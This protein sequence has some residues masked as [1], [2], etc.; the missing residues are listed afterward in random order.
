[1]LE[2]QDL[3][4]A[5][6]FYQV[7]TFG[8]SLLFFAVSFKARRSDVLFREG[9]QYVSQSTIPGM[10]ND[11]LAAA[12]G[13]AF[14]SVFMF[15]TIYRSKEYVRERLKIERDHGFKRSTVT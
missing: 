15:H 8:A 12:I 9:Y 7:V 5:R 13:F 14:G 1:M 11:L 10:V 3:D 6:S 2:K 4:H